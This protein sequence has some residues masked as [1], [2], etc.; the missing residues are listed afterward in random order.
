MTIEEMI[1]FRKD[2]LFQG[3]VQL[4]WFVRQPS[5]SDKAA[6]HF[7]F[8]GPD[9]H[10]ADADEMAA[11]GL[12]V[13][14]TATFTMEIADKLIFNGS[15][16]P[17][18]IGIAGYGTGKSHLALTLSTLF[19]RPDEEI[20]QRI[21]NNLISADATIGRLTADCVSSLDGQPFLVVALNGM[22]D[23]NLAGEIS[24]QILRALST[25]SIDASVL[26]NLRPRFKLAEN[27]TRSLHTSLSRDFERE[28][29]RDY[30]VEDIV[31]KLTLQ[32]EHVFEKVNRIYTQKMGTSIL[33][34]GNESLQDFIR[35][36]SQQY[37]GVGK[38]FAGLFIV[39]DEFGRYIEFAVQKPHVAG[40]AALQQLFEA[41]QENAE[42]VFMLAF[43][44][45]ELKAYASRVM[46]ERREEIDRY[47]TR[48]DSV[49]KVRLSSNL[50]T[51]IANLIEKKNRAAIRSHLETL[52]IE[53]IHSCMT[54]WFP[55]FKG[56]ALWNDLESF[57]RVIAEGCFPLHPLSTWALHK[58]TTVG[59]S[60]QQRSAL[61][62]LAEVME[63]FA[64][65]ELALGETIRPVDLLIPELISEFE[66]SERS[67]LQTTVTDSYLAVK[68]KYEREFTFGEATLLKGILLQH[69]IGLKVKSMEDYMRAMAMF[70]GLG[71]QE[72]KKGL[73]SLA[74]EYGVLEWNG[75]LNQYEIVGDAV[76]RKTFL[77]H[78]QLRV[79]EV[80]LQTRSEIF[81]AQYRQWFG[82]DSFHTDFGEKS[83]IDTREWH[84]RTYFGSVSSLEHE[85]EFAL[86]E[87]QGAIN[88]DTEKGQLIYCYVGPESDLSTLRQKA[89][90]VIVTKMKTL[91]MD[92][93]KGAPLAVLFLDDYEGKFGQHVA[94]YWVLESGFSD[95]ERNRFTNFVSD[96]KASVRE[97]LDYLFSEM[98][99]ERNLVFATEAEVKPTNLKEM[100]EQLFDVVYPERIPFPF[101]GFSTARGNAAKDCQDFCRELL[102]G[103]LDQEW[104][105]TKKP[106]VRKRGYTVL[107]KS[108]KIFDDNGSLLRMPKNPKV[109]KLLEVLNSGLQLE[110]S[111]RLEEGEANLGDVVRTWMAPPYGCNLAAAGLVL[112]AYLGSRKDQIDIILDGKVVGIKEWLD[113]AMPVNLFDLSVL[114]R[115]TIVKVSHDRTSAW[116]DLFEEWSSETVHL[117]KQDCMNK[118]LRL[119]KTVPIP[120][121]FTDRYELLKERTRAN[122]LEELDR[123]DTMLNEALERIQKGNESADVGY[124]SWGA[125]MLAEQYDNMLT[126]QECWTA[127]QFAEV[128]RH[129]NNAKDRVKLLFPRWLKDQTVTNVEALSDYSHYMRNLVGRNFDKIGLQEEKTRLNAHVEEVEQ[130]IRK[131]AEMENARQEVQ[132]FLTSTAVSENSRMADLQ[133]WLDRAERLKKNLQTARTHARFA[134]YEVD[135]T[136]ERLEEFIG[137]CSE[138]NQK[139]MAGAA[140]I[141]NHRE[142]TSFS[143]LTAWKT[144]VKRFIDIF[145]GR[146]R[147]V[148][149]F[150][151][152]LKQLELF[153]DHRRRLDDPDLTEDD[154]YHVFEQCENDMMD[155]FSDDSPPLDTSPIYDN[156]LKIVYDKRH[157]QAADWMERVFDT[158]PPVETLD[159]QGVLNAK[160]RLAKM[161]AVLSESQ[162]QMVQ[163]RIQACDRRL[164]ELEVEGLLASFYSLSE[165]NKMRFIERLR[166]YL[167]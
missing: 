38:P 84:Y 44:Q 133:E 154:L 120:Q 17:F 129:L 5:I 2:L 82:I 46:P 1:A 16:D 7:I 68:Q 10:G 4:G 166:E 140:D 108:W 86:R 76:P 80:D 54:Q 53:S 85:I 100:L 64:H 52:D 104:L 49:P 119:E 121:R 145:A 159:A 29:G 24:E 112:S 167:R 57:S 27:F 162:R 150:Q 41:V 65:K 164:D 59:R 105:S 97:E 89:S 20:A 13:V 22:E 146:E 9:Y 48:F 130:N 151:L 28:F 134:T 37:C 35:T 110:N 23:F 126:T 3:A 91:R 25:R 72:I 69:K 36:V 45:T 163:E 73:N 90:Q 75:L 26:E 14:D 83:K 143:D 62:L 152:V 32:D 94:E 153:E 51:V 21:L 122:A 148:E 79:E 160:Q 40:P 96:K 138:Q 19:S 103:N 92:P 128:E 155:S 113:K 106:Q 109:K 55:E 70:C 95:E 99:A 66:A 93:T 135:R 149:D 43:V 124:L 165:S 50:E 58:L 81:A 8:H 18:L 102:A 115:T 114:D 157:L 141:Y 123:F 139:H 12:L 31:Q 142:I 15:S 132:R 60:L 107:E 39:F 71:T 88:V 111:D 125:A 67:G 77:A 117:R 131:L 74:K 61:S 101:D 144:D 78:L 87:W 158:M 161:P 127:E 6:A 56:Y 63:Q 147:D 98:V 34:I 116:E 42:H 156:I 137:K 136:L 30:Q 47:L 11:W 118:A 33:A